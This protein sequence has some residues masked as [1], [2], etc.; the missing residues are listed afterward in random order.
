MAASASIQDPRRR[1]SAD[2]DTDGVG[3]A[4]S[5]ERAYFIPASGPPPAETKVPMSA[6]QRYV[7][8]MCVLFLFM[9]EFSMYIMEP[10]LQA[11]ME[12]LV[13]HGLYP[14]QVAMAPRA[15]PDSRCKNPNVQTTLAMARSWLMWVGMFVRKSHSCFYRYWV[16][17]WCKCADTVWIWTVS[18]SFARADSL[19]H[20]CR[21]VRPSA[22]PVL[23]TFGPRPLHH[24]EH[25]RL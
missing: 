18:N 7:I 10:P 25:H 3:E 12:D 20:G 2:M 21:Q 23:W 9:V 24:V 5:E 15:E 1:D 19:R 13:C 17:W 6:Q 8:L 22:C 4:D 14:D 16:W 11:I